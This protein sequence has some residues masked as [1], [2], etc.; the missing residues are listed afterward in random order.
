LWLR[1]PFG[2]DVFWPIVVKKS[3]IERGEKYRESRFF[4]ASEAARPFKINKEVRHRF[5]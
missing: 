4:D 3:K 1:N 5:L 2:G